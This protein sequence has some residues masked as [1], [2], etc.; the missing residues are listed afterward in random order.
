MYFGLTSDVVRKLAYEFALQNS[1]DMPMNWHEKS[2]AG[3]DWFQ[4]FTKRHREISLRQP[5]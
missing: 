3:I 2:K 1:K 5:E 4:G